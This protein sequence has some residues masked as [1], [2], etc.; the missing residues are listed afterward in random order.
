MRAWEAVVES[1]YATAEQVQVEL[2]AVGLPTHEVEADVG[3]ST[4]GWGFDGVLHRQSG[5]GCLKVVHE[6]IMTLARRAP[7]KC[8][9]SGARR[10]RTVALVHHFG[11]GG[12]PDV[13]HVPSPRL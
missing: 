10:G 11:K 2:A 13:V 1:V 5:T 9:S 6:S 12:A 7:H 3:G 8:R 4:L